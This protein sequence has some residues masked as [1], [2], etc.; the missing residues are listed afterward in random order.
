[1]IR[2]EKVE[3]VKWRHPITGAIAMATTGLDMAPRGFLRVYDEDE[4]ET[5][6]ATKTRKKESGVPRGR[7]SL[8]GKGG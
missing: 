3:R 5:V 6:A 4:A 8:F 1:M 7:S 2:P